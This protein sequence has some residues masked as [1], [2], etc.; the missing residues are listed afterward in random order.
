MYS[1][2]QKL[3]QIGQLKA[4]QSAGRK[5]ELNQIEKIQKEEDFL[6][7]LKELSIKKV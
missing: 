3:D 5:L 6:K 7:Q 2:L 4:E 1:Y